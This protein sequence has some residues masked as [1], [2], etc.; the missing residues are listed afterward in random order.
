M[1]IIPAILATTEQEYKEKIEKLWE[2]NEFDRDWVQVD[3]MDG[4]FVPNKSVGIDIIEKYPASFKYEAHLMVSDP[5]DWAQR[6]ENFHQIL[7]FIIPIELDK[8]KIDKFIGFVRAFGDAEIGFSFEPQTPL[9][10]LGE[11]RSVA[12][13]ILIMSVN[14]GKSGQEFILDSI[15]KIREAASLV[16]EN[17]LDCLVGVDGGVS[18]E[19]IKEIMEAGADYVVMGSHLLEGDIHANLESVWEALQT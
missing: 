16:K 3:L 19:N 5:Y 2:S 6:L 4:E 7:R 12:E 13:S 8:E 17:G 11:Y 14:S 1:Q 18:S 10:R 9:G 15:D